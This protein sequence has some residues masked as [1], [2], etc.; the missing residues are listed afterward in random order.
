M[1]D[2]ITQE[3]LE[4]LQSAVN[5]LSKAKVAYADASVQVLAYQN[6]VLDCDKKVADILKKLGEEYGDNKSIDVN[7]G[8]LIEVSGEE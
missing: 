1:S 4:E 8:E 6:Q 5:T 3:Q 2:K 7:T